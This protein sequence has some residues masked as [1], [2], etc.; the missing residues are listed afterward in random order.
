MLQENFFGQEVCRRCDECET[1]L[2]EAGKL[3]P[4]IMGA[5]SK[6]RD[7]ASRVDGLLVELRGDRK[8]IATS[9]YKAVSFR[10][11]IVAFVLFFLAI[12][13]WLRSEIVTASTVTVVSWG[14]FCYSVWSRQTENTKLV[15]VASPVRE[16]ECQHLLLSLAAR[17]E[18]TQRAS[19]ELLRGLTDLGEQLLTKSN[20]G[21]C[22]IQTLQNLSYERAI[23]SSLLLGLMASFETQMGWMAS[24]VP[25][26]G[27]EAPILC[28]DE[29]MSPVGETL[30]K[31]K[32][33]LIDEEELLSTQDALF[34]ESDDNP[35]FL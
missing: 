23:F 17:I 35:A 21:F 25:D 19:E 26:M 20:I 34:D 4:T 11:L 10:E 22:E 31:M 18:D 1:L 12:V 14:W 7:S 27:N 16:G 13:F 29:E 24:K 8:C 3:C 28:T 2:S 9:E 33:R 5:L 6:L 32:S 30:K 15:A